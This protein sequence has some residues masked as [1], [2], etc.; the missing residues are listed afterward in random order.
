[1]PHIPPTSD[2]S[3]EAG[4]G[5]SSVYDHGYVHYIHAAIPG[6]WQAGPVNIFRVFALPHTHV[7]GRGIY[8]IWN[9]GPLPRLGP[10]VGIVTR[11]PFSLLGTGP[12]FRRHPGRSRQGYVRD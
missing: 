4:H 8:G 1:M 9:M 5:M 12:C 10:S 7:A 11:S 6:S 2:A 3:V